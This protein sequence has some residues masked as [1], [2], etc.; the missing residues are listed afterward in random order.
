[1]RSTA[2]IVLHGRDAMVAKRVRVVATR[3]GFAVGSPSGV[4]GE[5]IAAVLELDAPGAVEAVRDWRERWPG[6]VILGYSAVPDPQL[7]RTAQRAG[8]DVVVNRGAL[9]AQLA[10]RLEAGTTGRRF[11]LLDAADAA[12]RLGLVC[13]VP[14][15]PVGPVAVYQVDGRLCAVSDRCP[16]AGAELSTGELAGAVLTCPRHGSQFDV[17]TGERVRGPADAEVPA[18][19]V[20]R[21]GGQIFLILPSGEQR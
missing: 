11:P 10:A 16:H 3:H 2:T 1:M 7:W 6:T 12:G 4:D 19:T 15:T 21:E 8:C 13:R 17:R 20:T 18:F 5:P 14:E 9:A